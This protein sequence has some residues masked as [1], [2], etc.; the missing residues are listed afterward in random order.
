MSRQMKTGLP[1]VCIRIMVMLPN[2]GVVPGHG[3]VISDGLADDSKGKLYC[4]G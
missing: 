2:P 1:L 4:L 3:K